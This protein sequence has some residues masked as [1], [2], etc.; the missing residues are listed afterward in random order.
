VD[1]LEIIGATDDPPALGTQYQLHPTAR[2]GGGARI[3][4]G[5]NVAIRAEDRSL[6]YFETISGTVLEM[7][8]NMLVQGGVSLSLP[9]RS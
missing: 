5:L 9:G 4:L 2:Y 7:K 6:V 3:V 8:N 1:D